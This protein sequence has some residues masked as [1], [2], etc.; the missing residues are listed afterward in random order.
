LRR[1]SGLLFVSALA[2]L[3]A[4]SARAEKTTL[5]KPEKDTC[6]GTS[7]QFEDT[8]SDAARKALKEHKLVFVLHVSGHFE[9]PRFT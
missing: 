2:L 7:I 3:L 4:G 8:P 1:W 6:H 9:D 5:T